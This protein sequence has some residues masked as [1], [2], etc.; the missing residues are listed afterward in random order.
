[1]LRKYARATITTPRLTGSSWDRVRTAST[2]PKITSNIHQRASE[3]LGE[4]F[5]PKKYLLTHATIV[6][7]VD[8][9]NAPGAKLGRFRENGR[10]INRKFKNYRV[11]QSSDK[12]INNNS[13]AW[14]R[15]VLLKSYPTFI[16]GMNYF[17]HVQDPALSK[18]RILDAVARDVGDSVYIDILVATNR[19]HKELIERIERRQLTTLSM[20]CRACYTICTKC[21][22]VAVDE[23]DFCH[24]IAFEKG[25]YFIAEDGLAYRIAELCGHETADEH[26]GVVFDEASWV[27][28]PAFTGAVA[29]GPVQVTPTRVAGR[30]V[31]FNMSK[32]PIIVGTLVNHNQKRKAYLVTGGESSLD[33]NMDTPPEDFGGEGQDPQQTQDT[34]PQDDTSH[35]PDEPKSKDDPLKSVE[36]DVYNQVLDRVRK[37]LKDTLTGP[38]P[39]SDAPNDTIIQQASMIPKSAREQY[40]DSILGL[41]K[42]SGGNRQFLALLKAHNEALGIYLP[43]GVYRIAAEVGPSEK[44]GTLKEFLA[45]C[46]K[47]KGTLLTPTEARV[48]IRLAKMQTQRGRAR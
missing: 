42:A 7:S 27:E 40:R 6:A 2:L 41:M 45:S 13:D 26:G 22:N 15:Q 30:G 48:L 4:D 14:S 33:E 24:C 43:T 1:M 32:S 21:G 20:G 44:Y 17:E 34:A 3:I 11:V 37:R 8:V 36:D 35:H 38:L 9:V 31:D 29:R 28:I 39:D 18:G 46:R 23:D 47:R 5:D 10:D 25:D 16:G 19:K 12:H